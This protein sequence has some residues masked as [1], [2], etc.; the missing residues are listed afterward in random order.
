MNVDDLLATA[1]F[2]KRLPEPAERKRIRVDSGVSQEAMA[3]VL[4][5]S[6]LTIG[7]Y[8]KGV[9]PRANHIGPYVELLEQLREIAG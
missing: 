5:L 4:G 1:S 3:E 7:R 9:R 8:E 6:S 2:Y